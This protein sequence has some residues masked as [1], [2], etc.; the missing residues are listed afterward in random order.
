MPTKKML[1]M[2]LH[3][4]NRSPSQRFRFEQFQSFLEQNGYKIDYFYLINASDDQKFY[5]AGHYLA[6]VFIL[7]KSIIKLFWISFRAGRFQLVFVQREAFMLGTVFF[8]RQIARKTKMVFDFDDSIWLQNVSKANQSLSFLKDA[9][10][11]AKLI[12]IADLVLAGNSY[13]QQYALQYNQQ[14]KLFPTVVDTSHY[15]SF[16]DKSGTS[17]CIGW[18]GSFSTVPYFETIVPVL[19]RLKKKYGNRIYFK[20]IGDSTYYNESLELRGTAWTASTELAELAELDIGLMPLP[21]DEWTKGKCALKG[22]LYMSMEQVAVLSD[23]GVN[24][25]VVENGIDGF[26]CRDLE[27]WFDTLSSLIE[28]ASLRRKIARNGR[29]KV[30]ESYSVASQKSKLIQLLDDLI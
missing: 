2:G 1:F 22:L 26:L 25:T 29:K 30:Q 28:D 17:I 12:E 5:A 8:E 21:D 9:Q 6:K 18:S 27:S 20:L 4:P 23:V 19:L 3:R 10:K 24:A 14:T 16:T 13:L 7:L 15:Q 11:T